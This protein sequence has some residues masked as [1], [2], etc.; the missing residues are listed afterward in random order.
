[1]TTVSAQ[2]D[3]GDADGCDDAA[4]VAVDAGEQAAWFA[5]EDAARIA[6][7]V[8][9]VADADAVHKQGMKAELERTRKFIA[10]QAAHEAARMAAEKEAREAAEAL[11]AAVLAKA[12]AEELAA[13][14]ARQEAARRA[15]AERARLLAAARAVEMKERKIQAKLRRIGNCPVGYAWI[16]QG[17]YYRC[18][19]GSHTVPLS[20]L[21]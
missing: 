21:T 1:V 15:A 19:G 5:N 4:V 10:E 9:A 17:T 18:A 12:A 11:A 2:A 20:A 8:Q 3:A 6:E 13:L 7:L 16:N 14:R